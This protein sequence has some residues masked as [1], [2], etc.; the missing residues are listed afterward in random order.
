M[1]KCRYLHIYIYIMDG[2]SPQFSPTCSSTKKP[3]KTISRWKLNISPKQFPDPDLWHWTPTCLGF[4]KTWCCSVCDKIIKQIWEKQTLLIKVSFFWGGCFFFRGLTS[5][6]SYIKKPLIVL[7][8]HL[9]MSL[10]SASGETP[11]PTLYDFK[12]DRVCS[13]SW[14]WK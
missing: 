12:S 6:W 8:P 2:S 14:S 4:Q 13:R 11:R 10:A 3:A 5:M 7:Q 9:P 1:Q